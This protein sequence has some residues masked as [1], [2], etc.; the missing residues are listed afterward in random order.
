MEIEFGTVISGDL[1][2]NT[3]LIEMDEPITLR[4]GNYAVI[5]IENI[6]QQSKLEEFV[7]NL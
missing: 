5:R 1:H 4:A 7:K 3:L 2:E 6:E